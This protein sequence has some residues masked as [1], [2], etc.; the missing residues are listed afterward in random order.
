M[1]AVNNAGAP[2]F[3]SNFGAFVVFLGKRFD[4]RVRSIFFHQINRGAAEAAASQPRAVTAGNF[5]RDIYERVE[6][7]N[8]VFEKIARAFVTL[9]KILAELFD[10]AF[11][12]RA[13]TEND[14]LD[15]ANDM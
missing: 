4:E 5:A 10:V 15:F 8:A 11:T 6:F 7:G 9:E 3:R 13:L 1:R 12:Q 14:A 2:R